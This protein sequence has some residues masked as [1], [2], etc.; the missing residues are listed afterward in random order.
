MS[1]ISQFTNFREVTDEE[2]VKYVQRAP[3]KYYAQLDPLPTHLVRDN[4]DIL[5]PTLTNI[6]NKLLRSGCM[7]KGYKHASFT[8]IIKKSKLKPTF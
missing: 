8:P 1:D 6:V 4:I 3:N 7:P 2:I 5:A